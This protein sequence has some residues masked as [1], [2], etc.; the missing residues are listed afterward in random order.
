MSVIYKYTLAITDE[1][2]VMVP[3]GGVFLTVQ[4]QNGEAQLWAV[5]DPDRPTESRKILMCGTG[6]PMPP[7]GRYLGTFQS[8]GG[9]LVFH[10]FEGP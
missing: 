2:Q 5:V 4:T 9:R 1:Q 3:N 8:H 6:N 7:V 10:V